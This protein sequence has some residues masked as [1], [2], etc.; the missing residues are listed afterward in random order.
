MTCRHSPG[1]PACS[2]TRMQYER[3]YGS[4]T[5]PTTPD[6]EKYEILDMCRCGTYTVLKVK[7]PNCSKCAYEG[8]KI[9][10]IP[11]VSELEM[12]KWKA[13]DPHFGD[14][15]ARNKENAAPVPIA[16]FPGS[17]G[18]WKDAVEYAELKNKK[19]Q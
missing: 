2:T 18:G 5:V 4:Y 16:R 6:I 14:L 1:D 15:N 12:L 13:I 7:Y 10:V 11:S 9:L 8:T 3:H 17:D 19:G